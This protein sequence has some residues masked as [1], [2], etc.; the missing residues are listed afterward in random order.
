MKKKEKIIYNIT[1][2]YTLLLIFST[3]WI[4]DSYNNA[5]FE[6]ILFHIKEPIKGVEKTLVKSYIME[7]II[8]TTIEFII[9]IYIIN[10]ILN[11]IKSVKKYK[12]FKKI[13]LIITMISTCLSLYKV[14]MF[15]YLINGSKNSTF[16]EENY[17]DPQ[18]VYIEFTT[19][20]RNLIY[21]YVE[22]FESTYL[23][24][25][26]GG[27]QNANL[28]PEMYELLKENITFSDT[29]KMGGAFEING[30]SWTAA[31][32]VAQTSGIPLKMSKVLTNEATLNN[33][34]NNVYSLGEILEKEG[35]NQT[36]MFGSDS[37]FGNRKNY[38]EHNG[39]YKVYDYYS[40]IKD[41]RI[42]ND[43]YVWW[44]YEDSKLLNYAK[45]ELINL[46]KK[47]KPFNLTFLTSNTHHIDGYLENDCP[48]KYKSKYA[49][50][51]TCTSYQI[52]EFI[53]WCKKQDFYENTTIIIVGDH[54]SM[55]PKFFAFTNNEKRRIFNVFINS[56]V[57]TTNLKNRQF[58]SLDMFP[59]TLASLGATIDGNR[60]AL[61]TNLFSEEKTI[62]EKYG[63]EKVNKEI[64]QK[65]NFYNKKILGYDK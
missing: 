27:Q 7:C 44:G 3:R 2:Y 38:F 56:A 42:P 59:T 54:L 63:L 57:T 21:I 28:I 31:A 65:S 34:L 37:N 39:N 12:I 15:E 16:I 32:L 6:Q 35:Y 13:I 9:I 41:S 49:N 58:S 36:I 29:E 53:K 55:D 45:E 11:L 4:L 64:S 22:S 20:K 17:V 33:Y 14:G 62:I 48:Q 1:I 30:T 43:Y 61:G 23:N 47:D 8:L 5:S 18:K 51:I 25:E 26:Q 52:N 19:E 24:K 10:K 60:L 50:V 40:A 46:S